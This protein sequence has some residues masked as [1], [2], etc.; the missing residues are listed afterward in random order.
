MML[1]H[2]DF[3]HFTFPFEP[4][5]RSHRG[6]DKLKVQAGAMSIAYHLINGPEEISQWV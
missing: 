3:R 6:A 2:P 4:R 1:Q 5:L